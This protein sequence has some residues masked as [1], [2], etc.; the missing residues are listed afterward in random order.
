MVIVSLRKI[1]SLKRTMLLVKSMV[2]LKVLIGSLM[3][4]LRKMLSEKLRLVSNA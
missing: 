4:L 3:L 1:R 2:F